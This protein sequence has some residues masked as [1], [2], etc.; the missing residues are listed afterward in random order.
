VQIVLQHSTFSRS[1]NALPVLGSDL[2]PHG[3]EVL[4][5]RDLLRECLFIYDGTAG[6]F[7]LAF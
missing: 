1:M 7:T 4:I 2:K 5:G 6:Q 3:F